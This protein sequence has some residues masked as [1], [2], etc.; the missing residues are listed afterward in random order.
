[1]ISGVPGALPV[2]RGQISGRRRVFMADMSSTAG[3]DAETG[4]DGDMT[5]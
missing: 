5:T 4:T 1:M 3:L 2:A